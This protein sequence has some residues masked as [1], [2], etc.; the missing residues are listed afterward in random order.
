MQKSVAIIIFSFSAFL[1]GAPSP[2][3]AQDCP[4]EGNAGQGYVQYVTIHCQDGTCTHVPTC[5]GGGS[6]CCVFDG[7]SY[8]CRWCDGLTERGMITMG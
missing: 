7:S 8:Q 4:V 5:S 3:A 6:T 2:S 1:F